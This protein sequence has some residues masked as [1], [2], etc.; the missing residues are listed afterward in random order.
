MQ[1]NDK[2]K[3]RKSYWWIMIGSPK[4]KNKRQFF[5]C[6]FALLIPFIEYDPM[7]PNFLSKELKHFR[8][9]QEYLLTH[10]SN[11]VPGVIFTT[12]PNLELKILCAQCTQVYLLKYSIKCVDQSF[13]PKLGNESLIGSFEKPQKGTKYSKFVLLRSQLVPDDNCNPSSNLTNRCSTKT[14]IAINT[15]FWG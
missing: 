10:L 7:G 12:K 9:T 4:A 5:S 15:V 2:T 1:G 13:W 11:S 6:Q 8:S 14:I 3:T